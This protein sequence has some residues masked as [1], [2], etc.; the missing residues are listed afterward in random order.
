MSRENR[1]LLINGGIALIVGL[2]FLVA[3][4]GFYPTSKFPEYDNLY[5][6]A[7]EI[8]SVE[9]D[10]FGL[11][12][13]RLEVK[14]GDDVIGYI[15]KGKAQNDFSQGKY[16]DVQIGINTDGVI[17]GID[18]IELTQTDWAMDIVRE[19]AQYY[20]DVNIADLALSELAKQ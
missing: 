16:I 12:Y 9:F 18:F 19:N 17:T 11:V 5:K 14:K 1:N 3:F 15:Y 20:K 4:Q 6:N 13:D 2:L 10:T 7:S 8:T